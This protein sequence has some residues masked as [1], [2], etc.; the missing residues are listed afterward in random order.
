[1][2]V[3][4]H[5]ACAK[6]KNAE[7]ESDQEIGGLIVAKLQRCPGV[8][9]A[10]VASTAFHTGRRGLAA[11]LLEY[12][13]LATD[14]VPLL[15]SMKEEELALEKAIESGDT[16]LVY[17]CILHIKQNRPDDFFRIIK[18]KPLAR[19]LFISYCKKRDLNALQV[20]NVLDHARQ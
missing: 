16:D 20:W 10:K 7:D 5:W 18:D 9:Y 19:N 1:M 17:L 13:P 14:Q 11:M 8:S 4:I 6:I 3:L 2:Q 12:E 15:V